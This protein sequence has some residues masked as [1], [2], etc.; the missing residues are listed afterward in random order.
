MK[1]LA[2]MGTIFAFLSCGKDE[3]KSMFHIPKNSYLIGYVKKEDKK[4]DL[5]YF[6]SEGQVLRIKP[7]KVFMESQ[8]SWEKYKTLGLVKSI[9]CYEKT[10]IDAVLYDPDLSLGIKA[11]YEGYVA[12]KNEYDFSYPKSQI[13]KY[14]FKE[15]QIEVK[16]FMKQIEGEKP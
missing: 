12:L 11:S 7:C 15:E 10:S 1:I 4:I 5:H 8:Y 6:W 14:L 9:D 2:F 3:K 13:E 16:D